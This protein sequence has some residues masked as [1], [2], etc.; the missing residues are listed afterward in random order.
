MAI[1]FK[2]KAARE[3][4]EL[5]STK[6]ELSELQEKNRVLGDKIKNAFTDDGAITREGLEIELLRLD[7][8]RRGKNPID[9]SAQSLIQ[10]QQNEISYMLKM[11][12]TLLKEKENY[13]ERINEVETTKQALIERLE[14]RSK[15][16][17]ST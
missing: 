7:V 16:N 11:E 12:A 3:R 14:R 2:D 6:E 13:L 15:N 17:A 5:E 10:G 4:Q 8:V 1:I 9:Q